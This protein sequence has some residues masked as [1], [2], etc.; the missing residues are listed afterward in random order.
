MIDRDDIAIFAKVAQLEAS[1]VRRPL[2]VPGHAML[3]FKI[4]QQ[5][6]DCP[7]DGRTRPSVK[8]NGTITPREVRSK[9]GL[10][11]A[12]FGGIHL[13]SYRGFH[14]PFLGIPEG[15]CVVT[16][17]A[18]HAAGDQV[19]AGPV[20]PTAVHPLDQ[21]FKMNARSGALLRV[22]ASTRRPAIARN[23]PSMI[24]PDWK[25]PV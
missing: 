12:R 24:K 11:D 25:L 4:D 5:K 3:G 13:P 23:P 10:A 21:L 16:K 15:Q 6:E 19:D 7:D 18:Q 9:A 17:A 2:G 20:D 1:A 8:F 14:L 22:T